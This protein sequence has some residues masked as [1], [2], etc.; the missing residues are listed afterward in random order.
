MLVQIYKGPVSKLRWPKTLAIQ[1][2]CNK[3]GVWGVLLHSQTALP[4]T[5]LNKENVLEPCRPAVKHCLL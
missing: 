4:R 3:A 5:D 2:W 1:I